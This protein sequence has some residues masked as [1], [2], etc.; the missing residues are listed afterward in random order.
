[1]ESSEKDTECNALSGNLVSGAT[2]TTTCSVTADDMLYL[3]D[4]K[5]LITME[6]TKVVLI[7]NSTPSMEYAGT[8]ALE[9][10][11]ACNGASTQLLLLDYGL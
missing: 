7:Q 11:D 9:L 4:R 10:I 8:M 6:P 1:M 2:T 5:M 3:A